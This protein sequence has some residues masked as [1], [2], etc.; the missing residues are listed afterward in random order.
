M[1]RYL[2]E[3]PA[4]YDFSTTIPVVYSDLNP[5]NHLA[6]D[7]VLPLVF[8][9]QLRYLRQ[10]GYADPT[11]LDG[12]GLF[13]INTRT[14]YLSQARHGDELTIE[15]AVVHLFSKQIDFV[16]HITQAESGREI[17]RVKNSCI[18]FHLEQGQ[19]VDIPDPLKKKLMGAGARW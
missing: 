10:L 5:A 1:S 9:A 7:R 15:L 8:E 13:L 12:I 4:Q 2:V 16:F 19:A 18:A 6:A 11:N 17:A 14:D 3:L